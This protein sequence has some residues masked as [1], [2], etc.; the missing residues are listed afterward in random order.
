MANPPKALALIDTS[1][2]YRG[3]H[4]GQLRK[5]PHWLRSKCLLASAVFFLCIM[6]APAAS[7]RPCIWPR[8][9]KQAVRQSPQ[10]CAEHLRMP[11]K[12]EG[13][14]LVQLIWANDV[15]GI[16]RLAPIAGPDYL[17]DGDPPLVY[18]VYS[19][20]IEA[21]QALIDAGA[22]P[23]CRSADGEN[24]VYLAG[25]KNKLAMAAFLASH[26]AGTK[27]DAIRGMKQAAE[28]ALA[29]K[30]AEMILKGQIEEDTGI[31]LNKPLEEYWKD[32]GKPYGNKPAE[33]TETAA[34]PNAD[35]EDSLAIRATVA[36]LPPTDQLLIRSGPGLNYSAM[37]QL[38]NGDEVTITGSGVANR[39][40]DW[41]PIRTAETKG[42]VR[43]KFLRR[44]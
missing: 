37:G 6:L 2:I 25:L 34:D 16:R 5:L 33:R 42:W 3:D 22:D 18:A 12:R 13:A 8:C 38:N 21:A 15:E 35:D 28:Y 43:G 26:G 19:G 41:Y 40:S 23:Q 20:N 14:Q 27:E 17:I 39:E 30:F 29:R 24:L 7:A 32:F 1:V 44:K 31:T 4:L 11:Q 36:G 9:N 10:L